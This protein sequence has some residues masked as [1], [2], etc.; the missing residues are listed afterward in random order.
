M[1]LPL[2]LADPSKSAF[3]ILTNDE[4]S[5]KSTEDILHL[6]AHRNIVI[7][8]MPTE[9]LAFDAETLQSLT[10]MDTVVPIQGTPSNYN[11][12]HFV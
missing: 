1:K 2:H 3:C 5:Q 7:T 4:Y 12:M 9:S 6:L 8:G 10:T 11:F